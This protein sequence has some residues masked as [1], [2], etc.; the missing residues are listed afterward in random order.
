VDAKNGPTVGL[1]VSGA[2]DSTVGELVGVSFWAG[3]F[4]ENFTEMELRQEEVARRS[5]PNN[6]N[7]FCL[8][9]AS[10]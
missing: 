9:E 2:E 4:V 7:N 10:I 6:K 1:S 3:L 5:E 8:L